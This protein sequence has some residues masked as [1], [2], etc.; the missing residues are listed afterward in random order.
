MGQPDAQRDAFQ[1][2]KQ[3][4]PSQ[5]AAQAMDRNGVL[6]YGLMSETAIGCWNSKNFQEF[7]G[8]NLDI[9]VSNQETLQFASGLKVNIGFISYVQIVK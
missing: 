7:G 8:N 3:V 2:Y 4:R 9:L 1:P 6:F 5:S